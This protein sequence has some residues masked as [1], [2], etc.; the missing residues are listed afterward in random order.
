MND[1]ER[2]DWVNNH[3]GLYSAQRASGVGVSDFVRA[4]RSAIDETV[5]AYSKYPQRIPP[6]VTFVNPPKRSHKRKRRT[7]SGWRY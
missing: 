7:V 2:A 1:S 3:E 4:N 5:K 6:G